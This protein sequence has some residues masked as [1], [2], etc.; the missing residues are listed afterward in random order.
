MAKI[1]SPD[2]RTKLIRGQSGQILV[3]FI[4]LIV[5]LVALGILTIRF[6]NG[7]IGELWQAIVEFIT[8]DQVSFR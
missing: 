6:V 3:E 2:Y 1:V 4:L 8:E 5:I 7:P